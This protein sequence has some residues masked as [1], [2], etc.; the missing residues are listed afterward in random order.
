MFI[1]IFNTLEIHKAMN[2]FWDDHDWLRST[3]QIGSI[4]TY[5][6]SR[7]SAVPTNS[8]F[9]VNLFLIWLFAASKKNSWDILTLSISRWETWRL[10]LTLTSLWMSF[11]YTISEDVVTR[12]SS[13]CDESER[14]SLTKILQVR[15]F[16]WWFAFISSKCQVSTFL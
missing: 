13:G 5:I 2:N 3:I 7:D 12:K 1:S 11:V 16:R 4:V 8:F 14:I 15:T 10:Q 6:L 9:V